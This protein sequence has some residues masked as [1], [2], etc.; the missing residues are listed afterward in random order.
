MM[1][2]SIGRLD[3]FFS[4]IRV[5]N[6]DRYAIYLPLKKMKQSNYRDVCES[7][8]NTNTLPPDDRYQP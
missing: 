3:L 5:S 1:I 7:I 6:G 4:S 8:L 2:H